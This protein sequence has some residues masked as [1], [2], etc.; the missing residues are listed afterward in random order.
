[1]SR[2]PVAHNSFLLHSSELMIIVNRLMSIEKDVEE[3]KPAERQAWSMGIALLAG[4]GV[5]RRW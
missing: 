5:G 4:V 2:W 3:R 1:M